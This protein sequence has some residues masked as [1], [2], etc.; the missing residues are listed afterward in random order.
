MFETPAGLGERLAALHLLR[1]PELD[2]P[3]ARFEG[4]G[5]G[6]VGRGRELRHDPAAERVYINRRQYFV[7]VPAQVCKKWLED[8]AGLT[9][10]LDE[11]Q[12]YCRII[13]ALGRTL[14]LERAIDPVY[15]DAERQPLPA[16]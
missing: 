12:T 13:T 15:A 6:R 7:P 4:E 8:R 10:T 16:P 11:I 2:R 1:A 14:E 3:Q 9:L 5:D